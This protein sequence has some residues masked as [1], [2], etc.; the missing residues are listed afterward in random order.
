MP[1]FVGI[2]CSLENFADGNF[3]K[4][5]CLAEVLTKP[6]NMVR[7]HCAPSQPGRYYLNI[8]VSPDWRQDDIRELACSFQASFCT[9]VPKSSLKTLYIMLDR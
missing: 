9:L 1:Y 7:I 8:Y 5:L 6:P 4:G 3:L 2:S